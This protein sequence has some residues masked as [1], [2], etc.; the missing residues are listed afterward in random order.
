VVDVAELPVAV[1]ASVVIEAVAVVDEEDLAAD[2]VVVDEVAAAVVLPEVAALPVEV[3]V[4]VRGEEQRAERKSLFIQHLHI[5]Q[6]ERDH[7]TVYGNSS[8][9]AMETP[10]FTT[11][12]CAIT[13]SHSGH[14][15]E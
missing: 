13:N 11:C 3:A 10:S 15:S 9:M 14:T 1:A 4:E 12:L 7:R 5:H 2:G 6:M 8:S